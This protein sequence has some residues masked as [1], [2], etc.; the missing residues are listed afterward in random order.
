MLTNNGGVLLDVVARL[1]LRRRSE[2]RCRS[3]VG[4]RTEVGCRS[5]AGCCTEVGCRND[6]KIAVIIVLALGVVIAPTSMGEGIL[7]S[8]GQ[9]ASDITDSTR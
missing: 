2:V 5:E 1:R 8:L 4:C 3:E 6:E 7:D 9:F